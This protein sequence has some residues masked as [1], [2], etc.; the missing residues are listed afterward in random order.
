MNRKK[1]P[2]EIAEGLSEGAIAPDHEKMFENTL[3][4]ALYGLSSKLKSVF[5]LHDVQGF[6]HAEIAEIMGCSIGTSKSQ[7][8][9]ARMKIRQYLSRKQLI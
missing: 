3:D 8:F 6:K 4:E 9:K 2:F 5:V 7:L 1:I